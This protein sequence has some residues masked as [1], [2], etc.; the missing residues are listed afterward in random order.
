M[1]ARFEQDAE[2]ARQWLA[3]RGLLPA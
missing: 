2:D 1:A 3:E